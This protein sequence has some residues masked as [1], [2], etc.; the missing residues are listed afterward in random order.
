MVWTEVKTENYL[1][2]PFIPRNNL[3]KHLHKHY[4]NLFNFALIWWKLAW[5]RFIS[6]AK[7]YHAQA[8]THSV[9][10]DIYG[11]ILSRYVYSG[12]RII[13]QLFHPYIC[14]DKVIYFRNVIF[15]RK[16]VCWNVLPALGKKRLFLIY[17]NR[18][19][20]VSLCAVAKKKWKEKRESTC[21]TN[22]H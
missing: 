18:V 22:Q 17:I 4:V 7:V 3:L 8:H 19:S 2:I 16:V 5:Q 6:I 20:V 10:D 9:C 14:D 12:K 13:C 21:L 1:R 15:V 11:F